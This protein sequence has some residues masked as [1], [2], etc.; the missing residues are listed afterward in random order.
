MRALLAILS[1]IASPQSI[2]LSSGNIQFF[3]TSH[4]QSIEYFPVHG[5]IQN[6][7]MGQL[8]GMSKGSA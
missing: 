3:K 4:H 5:N 2:F 7:N 1:A 8:I 6:F